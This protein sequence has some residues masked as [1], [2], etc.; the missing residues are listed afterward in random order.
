MGSSEGTKV[1]TDPASIR[2]PVNE[3]TGVVTSDSLAAES[4]SSGGDFASGN[5]G[6]AAS[7]QPSKGTTTNNTDTSGATTLGSAPDAEARQAQEGWSES[8]SLKA[9]G[10]LGK[11][12]G[13]GPTYNTQGGS[14][15]GS[16]PYNT[17]TGSG[18]NNGGI[19]PTGAYSG[20]ADGVL[21]N[22]GVF[23][24][25]GKNIT[26]GD[27]DSDAPN[28]S[29]NSEIATKDD[30]GRAAE[31]KFQRQNAEAGADAAGSR[32]PAFAADG[33]YDNLDE[34]SA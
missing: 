34:T 18:T 28:A 20:S 26:E 12:G 3:G 19:A 33:Q 31:N 25:K 10:N 1:T 30:P 32:K 13:V 27:F 5:P 14:N 15:S 6:V 23:A 9:G 21:E 11:E 22:Q 4:L 2:N 17:T 24:P 29:F 8:A 16:T 7:K